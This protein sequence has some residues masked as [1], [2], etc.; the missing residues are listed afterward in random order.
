MPRIIAYVGL[1]LL[2]LLV[3]GIVGSLVGKFIKG[4]DIGRER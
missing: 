3:I 2:Y 4:P 1:G